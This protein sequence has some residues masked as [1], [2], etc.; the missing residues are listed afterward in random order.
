MK[1]IGIG[2]VGE[3]VEIDSDNRCPDCDTL[4]LKFGGSVVREIDITSPC[5]CK[6]LSGDNL[7]GPARG[8]NRKRPGARCDSRADNQQIGILLPSGNSGLDC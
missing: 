4:N 8:L 7:N 1:R 6:Y 2:A 5:C 3:R